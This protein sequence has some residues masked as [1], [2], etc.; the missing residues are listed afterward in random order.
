M[1]DEKEGYIQGYVVKDEGD[2]ST[3]ALESGE[4]VSPYCFTRTRCR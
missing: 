4:L 3:V 2:R 1:P